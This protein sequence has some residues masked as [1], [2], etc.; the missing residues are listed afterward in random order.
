MGRLQQFE[1][2]VSR[3]E[4]RAESADG[5]VSVLIGGTGDIEVR[6]RP[7]ALREVTEERLAAKITRAVGDAMWAKRRPGWAPPGSSAP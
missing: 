2:E 6:L 1:E 7:G 3:F 5:T 4:A